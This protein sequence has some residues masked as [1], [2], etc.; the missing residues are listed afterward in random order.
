[1]QQNTKKKNTVNHFSLSLEDD[2][3]FLL[4]QLTFYLFDCHNKF[5]V[6]SSEKMN[7]SIFCFKI[8]V[9]L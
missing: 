2:L 8:R 1:M 5:S 9:C 4:T 7:L 3:V 6:K